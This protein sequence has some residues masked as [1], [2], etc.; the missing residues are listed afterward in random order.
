MRTSE[1]NFAFGPSPFCEV[2]TLAE[3]FARAPRL[4]YE[5]EHQ[6]NLRSVQQIFPEH[7]QPSS[8]LS[9]A[10]GPHILGGT[11]KFARVDESVEP[12]PFTPA[13]VKG[14]YQC[15]FTAESLVIRTD[16]ISCLQIFK[17]EFGELL[18][19]SVSQL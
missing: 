12:K 11:L 9:S 8:D 2:E 14:R 17:D 13:R 6:I 4:F 15:L 5:F 1:R 18:Q 7:L 10:A 19:K 16:T 3:I